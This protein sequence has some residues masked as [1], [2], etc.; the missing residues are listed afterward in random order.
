[1]T[2]QRPVVRAFAA[3]IVAVAVA[4]AAVPALVAQSTPAEEALARLNFYRQAAGVGLLATQS[5]LEQAA[6]NHANYY[7]DNQQYTAHEETPGM[8]GFTGATAAARATAAGYGWCTI[9]ENAA[10]LGHSANEA[11][12]GLVNTVF[13]RTSMISPVWVHFGF[14]MTTYGSSISLGRT[15]CSGLVDTNQ[16]ILSPGNGQTGVPVVFLP[17][18]ETP[19]PL[20][21]LNPA[22]R[23]TEVGGPVSIGTT[24][25]FLGNQTPAQIDVFEL[26]DQFGGKPSGLHV[27]N[28]DGWTYW[29]ALE[30]L[31]PGQTYQVRVKGSFAGQATGAFDISW[32]FVTR[33]AFEPEEFGFGL[34]SDLP[35]DFV[36]TDNNQPDGRSLVFTQTAGRDRYT[37]LVSEIVPGY[38]V[39][40]IHE[41][42]GEIGFLTKFREIGLV[43]GVPTIGYPLSNVVSHR[44]VPIQFFQRG[45][46]RRLGGR[47]EF[48]NIFDDLGKLPGVDDQLEAI[49]RIPRAIDHPQDAGQPIDVIEMR[50]LNELRTIAPAVYA[51]VTQFSRDVRLARYG[52]PVSWQEFPGGLVGVRFQ[53]MGFRQ[54]VGVTNPNLVDQVLGGEKAKQFEVYLK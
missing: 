27:V 45:V 48:L 13:H 46:M 51:F 31:N 23:F 12:D 35:A 47:V 29:M 26:T 21:Q 10:S 2:K 34:G 25:N 16:V 32:S 40:N 11:V 3:G 39:E 53:R 7:L 33:S 5:A 18:G 24:A 52:L 44:G 8:P 38:S 20:P 49:S 50:R 4:L 41:R 19:D 14:G 6:A 9:G 37:T 15:D 17:H 42:Y 22:D 1:M 43:N 28:D 36:V 30:P 54:G